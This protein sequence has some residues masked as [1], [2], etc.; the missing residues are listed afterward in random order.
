MDTEL[1]N[2]LLTRDEGQFLEF[3]SIYERPGGV[4]FKRRKAAD[5]AQDIAE[6]LSAMANADGGTLLLGIEDDKTV[7][8]LDY[9]DDKLALLR[10]ATQS[11]LR[12]PLKA[13]LTE[14]THAG[15]RVMIFEVYPSP[16]PHQLSDGRYLLRVRDQNLPFPADQ[17]A[18]LKRAK[19]SSQYEQQFVHEARFED[20]DP[21]LLAR[22]AQRLGDPR[23]VEEILYRDY[24]LL[25]F[26][27]GRPRLTL[28]ALLLFAKDPLRWHPRCGI[29]FVKFEGTERRYGPELNV[30]RRARIEYPL[31][32]LTDKAF[33][34]IREHVR[35]RT[36]LHDL[37]FVERFEYPTFA[38]Q[39]AIINAVAHRDYSL[40]GISTEVWMFD[41]RLEVRSPGEL[42]GPVTLERLLRRDR[43]HFSRNP[44]LVRVLTDLGYMRDLGEGIPRMFEVMEENYLRPPELGQ[45]GFMFQV[46]LRN[47]PVYDLQTQR[48]LEHF[49]SYPLNQR[50]RRILAYAR[51][52]GN[53][54][55]S[56]A[57]QKVNEVD[58]DLAYREIQ[59]MIAL[60]IVARSPERY[61]RMYCVVEP[62]APSPIPVEL[63]AVLDALSRQEYV[64]NKDLQ[65]A[66]HVSRVMVWK[67]VKKLAEEGFLRLEGVGSKTRYYPT[68]RLKAMLV[69]HG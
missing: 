53:A 37:L 19:A 21:D 40:T 14:L 45:D 38:W 23:P 39:E 3:K 52:H 10:E 15:Q 11:L 46:T 49:V 48:W 61:G 65:A 35:E 24:R 54:F 57:Y 59:E 56:R 18:T 2:R 22:F 7:T 44:L 4:G 26:Q 1:L 34:L 41:D 33:A 29:D 27:N 66:W 43:V 9:P 6:T 55:T 12:P 51:Q 50:Q 31:F 13:R 62:S 5:V 28:A 58:R 20:L 68:D 32:E 64:T 30:V 67:R 69:Q 8:G 42:P 16:V 25:D 36:V 63:V 60:G 17:I 47:T